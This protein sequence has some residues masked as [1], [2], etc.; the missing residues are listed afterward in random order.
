MMKSS[1]FSWGTCVTA[2]KARAADVWGHMISLL[3]SHTALLEK[4]RLVN[5]RSDVLWAESGSRGDQARPPK[6]RHCLR[7]FCKNAQYP[8]YSGQW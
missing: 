2:L 8:A 1:L 3:C 6:G 5:S 4:A 7:G